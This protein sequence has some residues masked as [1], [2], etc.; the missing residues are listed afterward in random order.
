[1]NEPMPKITVSRTT[2][3]SIILDIKKHHQQA[4]FL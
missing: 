2:G 4:V 3:L 1:M